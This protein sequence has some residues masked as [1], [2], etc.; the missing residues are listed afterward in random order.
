M[1]EFIV[2]K[3]TKLKHTINLLLNIYWMNVSK[4][5]RKYPSTLLFTV[6]KRFL[7]EYTL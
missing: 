4:Y 5:K 6:R 2:G 1:T 7:S 3:L